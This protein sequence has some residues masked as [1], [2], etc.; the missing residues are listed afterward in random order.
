MGVAPGINTEFWEE[1]ENDFCQD[2]IKWTDLLIS[3]FINVS[4]YVKL[5][6]DSAVLLAHACTHGR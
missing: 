3:V 2:L 6:A 5:S 4:F 1:K